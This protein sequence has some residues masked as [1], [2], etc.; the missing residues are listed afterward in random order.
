[1]EKQ[2]LNVQNLINEITVARLSSYKTGNAELDENVLEQYIYNI[3]VAEAFYPAL[4]ILEVTLRNKICLAVEKYVKHNWLLDEL[5]NQQILA[6]KEYTRLLESANKLK[7][8]NKKITNDRLIAEMTFGF[9]IH[10]FTKSYKP[11]FWDKKGFF[12]EVFPN[13]QYNNKLRSIAPIQNDLM[14]ILRL[15]NRIFHHEIIINGKTSVEANYQLILNLLHLMSNDMTNLL[16][17]TSSLQDVIK[18]KP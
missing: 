5:T 14:T 7:R 18:Q 12:E 6:D 10:L 9:W 3:K 15:R 1:M 8:K 4:S 2:I 11:K 13:Y 16:E 17:Y